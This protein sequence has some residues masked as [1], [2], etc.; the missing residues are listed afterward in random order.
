MLRHHTR[1]VVGN[2]KLKMKTSVKKDRYLKIHVLIIV[3]MVFYS[4]KKESYPIAYSSSDSGDREI[5]L[6][7]TEGKTKIKITNNPGADGYPDWSPDGKRIAFYAKYD[8][9]KTWSMHTM[10]KDGTDRKRLT[11]EKNKWDSSPTWS[12]DGEKIAFARE[13]SDSEGNWQEEVWIMNAD[14]SEQTQLKTISGRA[15]CFMKDGRILFHSKPKSSQIC[16]AN[17][18]GSNIIELTNNT[19]EDR[20]PKISPDGKHIAFISDRDGNQEIYVMNTNGSNQKR[21]TFNEVADWDPCWSPDGSKLIFA[22]DTGEY[23]DL[24]LI[25]KD[26]SAIRKFIINGSQPSWFK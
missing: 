15:P 14:G 5:Y 10:N 8:N 26:G 24:Y 23:L 19:A 13:Y 2:L 12:P 6:T 16:I 20:S 7:N 17:S 9:G 4:C 21:L 25:N 1:N 22:S 18:D 3:A 11:H